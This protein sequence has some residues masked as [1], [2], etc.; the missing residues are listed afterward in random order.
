MRK[1]QSIKRRYVP[2][3]DVEEI[4]STD[5]VLLDPSTWQLGPG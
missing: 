4:R 2:C 3:E 5:S 1:L